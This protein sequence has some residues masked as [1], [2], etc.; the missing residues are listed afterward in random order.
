MVSWTTRQIFNWVHGHHLIYNQCWEDPR[1]DHRA[2]AIGPGDRVL[3]LT[4]AGCN[5]LDYLLNEPDHIDAVDLNPRQNALLELKLAGIRK[6]DYEDFFAFF[7]SGHHADSAL[8]YRSALRQELPLFA[9]DY[10]DQQIDGFSGQGWRSSFYFRGTAGLVARLMQHYLN[11]KGMRESIHR[12]FAAKDLEEQR[13]IYFSEL[14]PLFW[15]HLLRWLSRRSAMMSC[16][17]VPRSQFL[18]VEKYYVGGMAKFIEDCLES[19]FALLPL[20]ENYFWR[21]YLFGSYTQNCCPSYL[22]PENFQKLKKMTDRVRTHNG[23]VLDFL[24]SGQEPITKVSLLDHMDWL[25]QNHLEVLR[26][27]WQGLL[28]R[29]VATTRIIWRSAS[30]QVDFVDALRVQLG[31]H[32]WRVGDLLR[33]DRKLAATLHEQDRVH[34]YGSFYIAH[35]R[36]S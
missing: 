24:T 19:V 21:L 27:Q 34:T 17:G 7:G 12:A 35:V 33:Y 22:R 23:S 5:T 6:L 4:S 29:S 9:R 13:H 8:L 18:Q 2:L 20:R 10:W 32:S 16:L 28:E 25:Y 14:K 26:A 1:L 15:S 30:M 11:F 31:G 3:V 36:M